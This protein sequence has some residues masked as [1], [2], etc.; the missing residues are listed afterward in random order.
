M[1]EHLTVCLRN[2]AN[3]MFS[4]CVVATKIPLTGGRRD[5]LQQEAER[6]QMIQRDNLSLS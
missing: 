3:D 4:I 1:R 2:D 6:M 5:D